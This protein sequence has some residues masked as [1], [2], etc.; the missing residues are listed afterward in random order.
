MVR[1]FLKTIQRQAAKSPR[2][3]ERKEKL[4]SASAGFLGVFT[5]RLGGL[6]FI[7]FLFL[8]S[9]AHAEDLSTTAATT[10][11]TNGHD[12]RMRG[13]W[14]IKPEGAHARAWD[15]YHERLGSRESPR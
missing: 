1:E 12:D 13:F 14:M 2:S 6:A 8:C 9:I 10:L 15:R 7:S 5:W 11:P 4:F 3:E